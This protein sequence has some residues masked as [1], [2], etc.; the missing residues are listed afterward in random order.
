MRSGT[1]SS[2]RCVFTFE[3][4]WCPVF[5]SAASHCSAASPGSAEKQIS[6][7][8]SALVGCSFMPATEAGM[9]PAQCHAVTSPYRLPAFASLVVRALISNQGWPCSNPMNRCPTVPVAPR[10]ATLR[11]RIA[12]KSDVS[13]EGRGEPAVSLVDPA[14]QAQPRRGEVGQH[15]VVREDAGTLQIDHPAAAHAGVVFDLLVEELA[16]AMDVEP[17]NGDAVPLLLGRGRVLAGLWVVALDECNAVR[18]EM[19]LDRA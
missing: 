8:R 7:S 11:L 17:A 9:S 12:V 6:A 15:L 4:T 14:Q 18:S 10:T 5:A 3:K 19:P 1:S 13:E 16:L 2:M